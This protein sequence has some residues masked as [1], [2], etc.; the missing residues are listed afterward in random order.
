M[1]WAEPGVARG[2]SDGEASGAR[3]SGPGD[4]LQGGEGV[5]ASVSYGG[6]KRVLV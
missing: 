4:D 5:E 6:E 1:E 2:D 3:W